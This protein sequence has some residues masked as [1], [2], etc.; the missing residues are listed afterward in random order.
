V[1]PS[2]AP[3]QTRAL[4]SLNSLEKKKVMFIG[5]LSEFARRLKKGSDFLSV[6]GLPGAAGAIV[7]RRSGPPA[8][9]ARGVNSMYLHGAFTRALLQPSQLS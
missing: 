6:P 8:R 5:A 1:G 4:V 2:W 7:H 9:A 3:R